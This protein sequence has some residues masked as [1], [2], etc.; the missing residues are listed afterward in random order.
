VLDVPCSTCS[1]AGNTCAFHAAEPPADWREATRQD[2]R[3]AGGQPAHR[4]PV[5]VRSCCDLSALAPQ[6]LRSCSRGPAKALVRSSWVSAGATR[7]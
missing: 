7:S 6:F 4:V 1:T 2:L 3:R 5:C